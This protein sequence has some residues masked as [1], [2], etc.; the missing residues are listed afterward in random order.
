LAAS[1]LQHPRRTRA[2]VSEGRSFFIFIV[3]D[4]FDNDL[5]HHP[6]ANASARRQ[7]R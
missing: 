4:V 7:R 1:W 6:L 2:A 5:V 3:E